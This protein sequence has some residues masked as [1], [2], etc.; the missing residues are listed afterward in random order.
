[1]KN[2]GPPKGDPGNIAKQILF[3][4]EATESPTNRLSKKRPTDSQFPIIPSIG[5]CE[6]I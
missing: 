4:G 1:M 3:G 5:V 2:Q 6:V